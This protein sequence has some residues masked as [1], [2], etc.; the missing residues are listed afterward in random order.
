MHP[1]FRAGPLTDT[2]VFD[3]RPHMSADGAGLGR[4]VVPSNPDDP[5][6]VLSSTPL[7]DFHKLRK[8]IVV[9]LASPEPRHTL[10]IKVFYGYD[11]VP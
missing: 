11:A 3:A 7:Q 10:D 8:R 2:E 6:P 1:T 5:G 4:R 9:D